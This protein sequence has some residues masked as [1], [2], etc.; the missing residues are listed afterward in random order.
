MDRLYSKKTIDGII[1]SQNAQNQTNIYVDI[2]G[3]G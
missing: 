2:T 1:H 3:T